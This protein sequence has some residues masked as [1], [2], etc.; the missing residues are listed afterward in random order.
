M[1]TPF[2]SMLTILGACLSRQGQWPHLA[3][4]ALRLESVPLTLEG[5]LQ[6]VADRVQRTTEAG[7]IFTQRKKAGGP[8]ADAS[9]REPWVEPT[10]EV[11]IH[12]TTESL[13]LGTFALTPALSF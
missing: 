4:Q 10:G 1:V 2:A 13:R 6:K 9:G 12:S 11:P 8:L 5:A 3:A 7:V